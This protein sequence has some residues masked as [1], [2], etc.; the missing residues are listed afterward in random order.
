M[1]EFDELVAIGEREERKDTD[2]AVSEERFDDAAIEEE[3]VFGVEMKGF[4]P[5]DHI[6]SLLTFCLRG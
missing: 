1:C 4:Q 2:V 3:K 5:A 6:E